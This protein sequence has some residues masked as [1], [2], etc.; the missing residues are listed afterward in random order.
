MRASVAHWFCVGIKDA[1]FP[2][3]PE[4]AQNDLLFLRHAALLSPKTLSEIHSQFQLDWW[5]WHGVAHWARV[6]ENGLTLC[7]KVEGVRADVVVLFALFHDACRESEYSDPE[8]GHRAAELAQRYQHMGALRLDP[9]GLEILV[10]ACRGHNQ[11]RVSKD[12]TCGVCWDADRLDLAR[13]GIVPSS[14]FLSTAPARER[15]FLARCIESSRLGVFP[16][17]ATWVP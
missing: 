4:S 14:R 16:R 6:L 12:A 9:A 13:V 5:G 11:G 1:P 10:E 2:P 3:M 8:H 15:D 17:R 7:T